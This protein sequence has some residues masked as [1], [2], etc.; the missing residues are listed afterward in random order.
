M[1]NT[2]VLQSH[3]QPLPAGWMLRCIKTVEQWASDNHFDYQF[4]DDSIFEFIH[5]DLRQKLRQKTVIAS[6]LARLY[7]LKHYLEKNYDTVIWCDADFL[8]FRPERFKPIDQSY[9]LGREVWIQHAK[10]GGRP[11]SHIKVHNAYLMFRKNNAFLDFYID[12]AE[13]LLTMNRGSMPPQFIGPKLLTAIHNVAQCP[14]AESAAMFSPLVIKDIIFGSKT[15]LSLFQ[16]K[17]RYSIDAANL[18]A[19]LYVRN[20]ISDDQMDICIDLLLTKNTR[21]ID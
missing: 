4:Y 8:I 21:L 14:V 6:D 3:T 15:A 7:L 11:V 5:P 9:A 17:S 10:P 18:C 13:R 2:I 20:K 1:A 16:Q 19:S 12:T